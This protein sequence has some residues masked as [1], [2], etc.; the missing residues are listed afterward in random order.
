MSDPQKAFP[1]VQKLVQCVKELRDPKTGC[2]W[3]L[4]QSHQSLLQYLTEE[5]FEFIEAIETKGPASPITHKELADLILQV[6]L[7]AQLMSEKG[8]TDFDRIA[9]LCADKIV[10]RHPHVFGD[11]SQRKGTAQEVHETWESQKRKKEPKTRL[12]SLEGIPTELPALQRAARLGDKA[13]GFHFD[14]PD[15]QSVLAK[16]EEELQEF[17][18]EVRAPTP[19]QNETRMK[20]EL[21]DLF[22]ALAQYARKRDWD[23]EQILRAANRKF[24]SRFGAMEQIA[25]TEKL[26]WDR[27]TLDELETLWQRAKALN[28][29]H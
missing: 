13:A 12:E 22:F 17:V 25:E 14:W 29:S 3:D 18:S 28:K 21:G 16:I 6:A 24:T 9:G 4:A 10:E 2:P 1:G 8:F 7:H 23:P 20:E 19:S 15:A 11:A 26:P 5:S 27:M